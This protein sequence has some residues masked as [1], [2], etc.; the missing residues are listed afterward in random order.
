MF[1]GDSSNGIN[2]LFLAL[3]YGI[4][5]QLKNAEGSEPV[6]LTHEAIVLTNAPNK[7]LD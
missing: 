4:A 7:Q 3:I 5:K 1:L 2:S 6:L